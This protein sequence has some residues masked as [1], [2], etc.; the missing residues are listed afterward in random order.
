LKLSE[1]FYLTVTIQVMDLFLLTCVI[2]FLRIPKKERRWYLELGLILVISFITEIAG[3]I[4]IHVFHTNMNIAS[5]IYNLFYLPL[6]ILFYRR[7]SRWKHRNV[8]SYSFIIVFLVFA[9]I[10][11]FYIQGWRNIDSY[12]M[13]ITAFSF[14][15]ISITYY[16]SYSRPLPTRP[17]IRGPMWWINVGILFYHSAA[18]FPFLYIDYFVNILN[19]NLITLWMIH[20]FICMIYCIIIG[21]GLHLARKQY[22]EKQA[23]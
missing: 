21:Y 20:H 16:F 2:L 18:F 7:N 19:S 13:S 11:L 6:G 5:S 1:T 22:L 14:I 8:L 3:T 23:T 10:N 9:L 15:I 17:A 12:T 4:G